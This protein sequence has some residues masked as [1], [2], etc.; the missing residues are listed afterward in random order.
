MDK[1][2]A[3]TYSLS[4]PLAIAALI[5]LRAVYGYEWPLP[6]WF[7]LALLGSGSVLLLRDVIFPESSGF[8]PSSTRQ[9][10]YSDVW[11][12]LLG[13]WMYWRPWGD[14]GLVVL[15]AI[16]SGLWPLSHLELQ[17]QR[18]RV[19]DEASHAS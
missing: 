6:G 1:I 7:G 18:G 16:A 14:I 11:L 4:F 9:A 13:G 2:L 10:L 3:W 19:G 8:S 12:V 17:R 15:I 5:G